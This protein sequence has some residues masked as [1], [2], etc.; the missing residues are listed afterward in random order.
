MI[1]SKPLHRTTS[2]TIDLIATKLTPFKEILYSS[3][4]KSSGSFNP[5][6]LM[7]FLNSSSASSPFGLGILIGGLATF[8]IGVIDGFVS[9]LKCK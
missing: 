3:S 4:S 2:F 7:H 8:I 9:P 1:L 6:S 5:N